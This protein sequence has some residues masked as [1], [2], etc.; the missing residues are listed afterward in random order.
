MHPKQSL[1]AV[2]QTTQSLFHKFTFFLFCYLWAPISPSNRKSFFI[3]IFFFPS[4]SQYNRRRRRMNECFFFVTFAMCRFFAIFHDDSKKNPAKKGSTVHAFTVNIYENFCDANFL[5]QTNHRVVQQWILSFDIYVDVI[6][7]LPYLLG[8]L[9]LFI[10]LFI[11]FF[12]ALVCMKNKN[13][14][15]CESVCKK[16]NQRDVFPHF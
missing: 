11:L 12:F 7:K 9:I 1:I 8:H 15:I 5:G 6:A 14:S 10:V 3:Y 4:C 13:R 2:N 16:F